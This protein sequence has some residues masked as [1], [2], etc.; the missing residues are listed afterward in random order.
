MI[1]QST[2]GGWALE[3]DPGLAS[4]GTAF[5]PAVTADSIFH[6]GGN[7]GIAVDKNCIVWLALAGSPVAWNGC[8]RW[9]PSQTGGNPANGWV[10]SGPGA[11]GPG[12][13]ITVDF[14]TTPG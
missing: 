11:P 10:I 1:Y 2:C 6:D 8:V 7:Y 9:D 4:G 14:N 12:R 5:G 3:I 13:G